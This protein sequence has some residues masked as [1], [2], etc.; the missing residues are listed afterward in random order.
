MGTVQMYS[1]F[2]DL[3]GDAIEIGDMSAEFNAGLCKH[4]D[5]DTIRTML[6]EVL[7]VDSL[8]YTYW[9]APH[10]DQYIADH[11]MIDTWAKFKTKCRPTWKANCTTANQRV[12]KQ[13]AAGTVQ[14]VTVGLTYRVAT[15]LEML[16]EILPVVWNDIKANNSGVTPQWL[17]AFE[18]TC[19]PD[20]AR[21]TIARLIQ[22]YEVALG[23]Y[24]TDMSKV[25]LGYLI[26]I[27]GAQHEV[28][29]GLPQD[30]VLGMGEEQGSTSNLN[31]L[32]PAAGAKANF[33]PA[34]HLN[35]NVVST[36]FENLGFQ[37]ADL[38][39]FAD[40]FA[41]AGLCTEYTRKEAL[42]TS[43]PHDLRIIFDMIQTVLDISQVKLNEDSDVLGYT[44]YQNTIAEYKAKLAKG[45]LGYQN[46]LDLSEKIRTTTVSGMLF[47]A[48]ELNNILVVNAKDTA[49]FAVGTLAQIS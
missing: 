18:W 3:D 25:T 49:T 7:G 21:I 8:H 13:L 14:T 15:L 4:D 46:Y 16:A 37:P 40:C 45:E 42:A 28:G 34:R 23:G 29:E 30:L 5:F 48:F 22:L 9:M 35:L 38:S 24:D 43:V 12:E 27:M 41:V 6:H 39:V 19:N 17:S 44:S 47:D 36:A 1:N 20:T 31:H 10:A 2:G 26:R 11:F 32:F 33:R